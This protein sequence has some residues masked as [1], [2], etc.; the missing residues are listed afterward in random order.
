MCHIASQED[1]PMSVVAFPGQPDFV[2]GPAT[3]AMTGMTTMV[4]VER[5]VDS[6]TAATTRV[7]YAESLTRVTA[8][9]DPIQRRRHR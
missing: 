1:G 7:G 2:P 8:E 6:V 5:F 9:A 3:G 4:A